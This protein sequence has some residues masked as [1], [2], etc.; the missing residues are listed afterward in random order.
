MISKIDRNNK[1]C[2]WRYE[3]PGF[4]I[5]ERGSKGIVVG[6]DRKCKN[7]L[8]EPANGFTMGAANLYNTPGPTVQAQCVHSHFARE[9]DLGNLSLNRAYNGGLGHRS[10]VP[11]ARVRTPS[12]NLIRYMPRCSAQAQQ[13]APRVSGVD[14]SVSHGDM[15]P[16][17]IEGRHQQRLPTP[18]GVPPVKVMALN[19][20]SRAHHSLGWVDSTNTCRFHVQS[21][22]PASPE[23]TKP[24]RR[25]PSWLTPEWTETSG[26]SLSKYF[27]GSARFGQTNR[28]ST[29]SVPMPP[30]KFQPLPANT[31]GK[32]L[33]SSAAAMY[34][35]L[36]ITQ[37]GPRPVPK[38]AAA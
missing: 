32:K 21:T 5:I 20:I 3:A 31:L 7:P 23:Y 4:A 29:M 14:L 37:G 9:L 35:G 12:S 10:T 25:R 28:L 19:A 24:P 11:A 36:S 2:A 1:S 13:L 17:S 16:H 33:P 27:G 34:C 38:A 15:W 22:R 18:T 30:A 26:N 8:Q 6:S